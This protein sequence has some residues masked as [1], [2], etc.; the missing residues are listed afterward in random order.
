VTTRSRVRDN[1]VM[2]EGCAMAK[3]IFKPA[4]SKNK[5]IMGYTVFLFPL[6]MTR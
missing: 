3:I 5:L 4:V 6:S 2:D 1:S